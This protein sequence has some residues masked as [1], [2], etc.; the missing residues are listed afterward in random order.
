[1]IDKL[2]LDIIVCPICYGKLKHDP[3]KQLLVCKFNGIV[4]PVENGIPVLLPDE[5]QLC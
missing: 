5:A 3:E 1:M 2:L 4:F